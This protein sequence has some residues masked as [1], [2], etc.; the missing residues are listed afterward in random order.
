LTGNDINGKPV[1][2]D[3]YGPDEN[4]PHR[5]LELLYKPCTPVKFDPKIPD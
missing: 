4:S 3:I 1:R 2:F 5:R